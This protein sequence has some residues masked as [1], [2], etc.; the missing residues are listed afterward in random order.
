M[1]SFSA[2]AVEQLGETTYRQAFNQG[3]LFSELEIQT[4]ARLLAQP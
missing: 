3:A 4:A 1:D 2:V